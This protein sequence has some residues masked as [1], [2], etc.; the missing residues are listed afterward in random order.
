MKTFLTLFVV[1]LFDFLAGAAVVISGAEGIGAKLIQTGVLALS[2]V[3]AVL[4]FMIKKKKLAEIGFRRIQKGSIRNIY[5]AVPLIFIALST[6]MAGL[7]T[8]DKRVI[9]V[10]V[11]LALAAGFNEEIYFRG[12]LSKLWMPRGK[13]T[14]VIIS[15]CFFA[16][17]HLMNVLGGADI[18]YTLLQVG[19]AFFYGVALALV[20][21]I[22]D[23]LWPC[24]FLHFF[25]DT[26]AFMGNDFENEGRVAAIWIAILISY[27]GLLLQRKR[28]T[29]LKVLMI[30]SVM[31]CACVWFGTW[32]F[33]PCELP[34]PTG[35]YSVETSLYT[36]EDA[37]REDPYSEKG[38]NR[39]VTIKVWYPD[40]EGKY[41]LVVFSH[42]AFGVIDSNYSTCEELASHGYV[43]VSVG[44]PYH[45]MFV[46]DTDGHMTFVN[47]DFMKEVM[48]NDG[49][50][51]E[52]SEKKIYENS[53]RWMKLRTD[54]LQFVLDT[55]LQQADGE[56]V[57]FSMIDR[58]KIGMF[59]H[60]L[61]GAAS[62]EMG[63]LR[64]D[65]TAV[66]D[67]EGTMLGEFNGFEN[68]FITY[69]SEP[70]PIPILD[71]NGDRVK[72]DV[73]EQQSEYP[74][75]VYVNDYLG[76]R[77]TAYKSVIF[78]GTGHLNYTDLP[79]ISP[80][81]ARLLGVGEVDP[82]TCIGHVNEMVQIYFDYYLKG[83]GG[84]DEIQDVY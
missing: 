25:H 10:N 35:E 34:D 67:L 24:I 40:A 48:M 29:L 27:I 16:M 79:I 45:A 28:K 64:S 50:Y 71:V 26:F 46:E 75:L 23:S 12:I 7:N 21:L 2:S 39:K 84:L 1:L 14:G 57:P 13:K 82:K 33:P 9:F 22:T 44:H 41:P 37:K 42:G 52:E 69:D 11:L 49:T 74:D 73:K 36:W 18:Q 68:G 43:V 20:F 60:S 78:E 56:K 15:S 31:A 4:Y 17:A 53:I 30:L 83:I 51:S 76:S 55:L 58:E 54:D 72:E 70:Y 3:A 62:V 6:L 77:A 80:P 19:F 59:G 32:L 65:I 47:R 63:R 81:L 61:G 38:E 66:I 8:H 5:Y